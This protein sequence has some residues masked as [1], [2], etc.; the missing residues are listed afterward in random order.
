MIRL[1]GCPSI[2]M[3]PCVIVTDAGPTLHTHTQLLQVDFAEHNE[4]T[5]GD[6]E[7]DDEDDHDEADYDDPF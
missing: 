5:Y 6:F 4:D 1:V 3:F 2:S 7:D